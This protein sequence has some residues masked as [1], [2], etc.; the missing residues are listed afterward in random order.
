M[1]YRL[2]AFADEI[3]PDIQLQMDHLLDNGIRFCAMRGANAKNVMDLEDFQV[4]LTKSQFFNRGVRF[5]CIGSPVGKYSITDPLEPEVERLKKAIKLAR[6]FDTKVIRVFSFYIPKGEAPEKYEAE[7]LSRMKALAD[8]AKAEGVNLLLENEKELYGDV[9][10]RHLQIL[11]HI[12][13]PHVRAAF[14]FSN[15]VQCGEN[16]LNAWPKLKKYVVDFHVKDCR[17]SDGAIVP[18]GQGDGHVR[19]ILRD[20][21][22]T[23]WAGYLTLEPHLSAAGQYAGFTGPSL[24]KTAAEALKA[25]LQ[26]VGAK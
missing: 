23:N 20:A 13:S 8:T 26:E 1:P 9:A 3:S 4:N 24:F 2:S 18:A 14:D 19:E 25:I 10:D 22:A 11:A 12:N 21:F 5:S 7:V 15:Y 17:K 6:A 16:P